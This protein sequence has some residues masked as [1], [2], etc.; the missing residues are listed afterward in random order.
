MQ[1]QDDHWGLQADSLAPVRDA[2]LK[3]PGEE[4]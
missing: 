1:K 2:V 4:G 3:E